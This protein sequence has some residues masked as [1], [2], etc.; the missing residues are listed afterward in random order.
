M[1]SAS[2]A[3]PLRSMETTSSALASSRHDLMIFKRGGA[4]LRRDAGVCLTAVLCEPLRIDWL[5]RVRVLLMAGRR[6]DLLPCS[7]RFLTVWL[8]DVLI[9]LFRGTSGRLQSTAYARF[10]CDSSG[11]VCPDN[12]N[13]EFHPVLPLRMAVELSY[14]KGMLRK[15]QAG[16]ALSASWPASATSS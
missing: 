11:A 6:A 10:C 8:H 5:V 15:H 3:L 4:A 1:V 16:A 9:Y 2:A 7:N 13:R 14:R 12:D